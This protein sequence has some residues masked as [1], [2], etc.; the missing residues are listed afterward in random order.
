M[1]YHMLIIINKINVIVTILYPFIYN[2]I[3][4]FKT[5]C[6]YSNDRVKI[7]YINYFLLS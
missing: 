3:L 5:I 2:I 4:Y 7:N 6:Q 1:F